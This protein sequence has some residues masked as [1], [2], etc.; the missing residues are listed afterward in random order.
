MHK[1]SATKPFEHSWQQSAPFAWKHPKGLHPLS[2]KE[3]T[4]HISIAA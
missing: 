4:K 1:S 2:K 3:F